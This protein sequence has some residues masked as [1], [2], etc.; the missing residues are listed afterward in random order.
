[1]LLT[2]CC[3]QFL[4]CLFACLLFIGFF[5]CLSLSGGVGGIS[6]L[7]VTRRCGGNNEKQ[8]IHCQSIEEIGRTTL[9][10]KKLLLLQYLYFLYLESGHLVITA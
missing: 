1:M 10:Q 9:P 2:I 5:L 3:L 7:P 8:Q 4:V 6:R